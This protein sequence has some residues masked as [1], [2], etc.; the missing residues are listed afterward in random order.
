MEISEDY[1]WIVARAERKTPVAIY[2]GGREQPVL[3]DKA[4]KTRDL[5]RKKISRSTTSS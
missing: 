3:Y 5:L 4:R 1:N 2:F